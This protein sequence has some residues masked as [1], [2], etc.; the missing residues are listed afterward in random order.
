MQNDF[1]AIHMFLLQ[2]VQ[3]DDE[4]WQSLSE[5]LVRKTFKKKELLLEEGK[6][7]KE[8]G[9]IVKGSFR[10]YQTLD[11][12]EITTFF[13]FENNW[14]SAY[15]SFLTRQPSN[16]SIEAMEN[17]EVLIISYDTLQSLYKQ[18]PS[19]E[20]FGRLMAEYLVT[21][22][23][24]RLR[25]MLLKTPEERYLSVLQNNNEYFERVPLHYVAS[26]LGIKAESL[27]RIRKRMMQKE[28]S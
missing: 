24:E 21:C 25:S 26:F 19:I 13:S 8:I 18:Y 17:S 7:C 12:E 16:T 15:S 10:Y 6:V 20:K 5:K 1:T 9:F 3:I 14:T 23:D 22:L 2:M 11:G 28:I 27:S 4:A